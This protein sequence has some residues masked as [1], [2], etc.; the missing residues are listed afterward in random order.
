[1]LE[2]AGPFALADRERVDFLKPFW[3]GEKNFGSTAKTVE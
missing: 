2:I 3:I 1:M